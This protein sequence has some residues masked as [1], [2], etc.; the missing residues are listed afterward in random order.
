MI[1][2]RRAATILLKPGREIGSDILEPYTQRPCPL[3]RGKAAPFH[4]YRNSHFV[5][6]YFYNTSRKCFKIARVTLKMSFSWRHLAGSTYHSGANIL[7]PRPQSMVPLLTRC[8]AG[9]GWYSEC[10]EANWGWVQTN[11]IDWNTV[12][13]LGS[14]WVILLSHYQKPLTFVPLSKYGNYSAELPREKCAHIP[15]LYFLGGFLRGVLG[16]QTVWGVCPIQ[17]LTTF[18]VIKHHFHSKISLRISYCPQ[19]CL[20]CPYLAKTRQLFP[21]FPWIVGLYQGRY[22]PWELTPRVGRGQIFPKSTNICNNFSKVADFAWFL[23]ENWR[24]GSTW[25]LLPWRTITTVRLQKQ[26]KN[27]YLHFNC[28]SGQ[29]WSNDGRKRSI[30]SPNGQKWMEMDQRCFSK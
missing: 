15:R 11:K 22:K 26:G 4:R 2:P 5:M 20:L 25:C 8:A 28:R 10:N 27:R 7:Q 17:T 29:Y 21:F 19:K 6:P 13:A 24:G 30:A 18:T 1:I 3:K 14:A 12:G 9:H 16:E 23:D